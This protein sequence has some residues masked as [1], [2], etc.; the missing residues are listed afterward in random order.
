MVEKVLEKDYTV[1]SCMALVTSSG[2]KG[3]REKEQDNREKEQDNEVQA[4]VREFCREVILRS[5][6]L[7][8]GLSDATNISEYM[9]DGKTKVLEKAI[10][11]NSGFR[12]EL[13]DW[14]T[15]KNLDISITE[16]LFRQPC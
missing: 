6:L 10:I 3:N 8:K 9:P 13:K 15:R 12:F 7:M 5:P 1:E 14:L 2:Q 4:R 11:E 16:L